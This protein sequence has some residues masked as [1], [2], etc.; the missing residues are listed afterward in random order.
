MEKEPVNRASSAP[1]DMPVVSPCPFC[2][3]VDG[4]REPTIIERT[5]LTATLLNR[6]QFE[7]GQVLV[8]PRRHAPTLLDLTEEEG[9]AV[10]QAAQRVARAMVKAFAPEGITVYQN[11][12]VV[13]LQE[14]PHYHMHVV[15]RRRDSGWGSGPAHIAVLDRHGQRFT[16]NVV[17]DPKK[18]GEIA[19]RLRAHL[20]TS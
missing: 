1:F 10:M 8:M 9:A 13:S 6:R 15:P 7:T 18:A 2:E 20:F 16:D 11:N 17:P 19:A 12:G 4:G 14:I 5:G 3:I